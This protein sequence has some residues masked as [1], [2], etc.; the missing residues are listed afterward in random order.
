[1]SHEDIALALGISRNTLERYFANELSVG[2]SSK[3]MDAMEGLHRAAKKG[4]VAAAKQ[5]LSGTM[6]TAPPPP[7]HPSQARTEP[8]GKKEQA[9]AAAKTAQHGTEWEDLLKP[10]STTPLQ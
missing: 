6:R 5:Y 9:Q 3:R 10:A 4:N 2:A 7:P 8:P 1:M